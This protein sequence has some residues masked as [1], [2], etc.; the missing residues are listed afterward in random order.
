MEKYVRNQN[1]VATKETAI[2]VVEPMLFDIY[3]KQKI[4]SERPYGI[5]KIGDYWV[6]S[7]SLSRYYD[8]GGGF[9][10]IID[11]KDAK[12]MSITHYK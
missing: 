8:F 12:V 10:I 11:A 4:L 6:V 5:H 9:G 7:G 2:E 1:L 3:G